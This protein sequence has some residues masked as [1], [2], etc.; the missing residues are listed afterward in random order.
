QRTANRHDFSMKPPRTILNAM[1]D[2]GLP[3]IGVGKIG[4][5]FAGEGITQSHPTVSNGAGM[6]KI[7]SLWAATERGFIFANLVDFDMLYGHRRDVAGYGRALA[8]FD[9][10]LGRFLRKVLPDDLLVL[11]AD[12][13]ND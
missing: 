11:T 10:W 5:I 3:V 8:E 2:H 12:H 4:D 1:A 7:E 9:E 13:G 6:D